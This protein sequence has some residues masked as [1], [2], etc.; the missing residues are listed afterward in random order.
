MYINY[1]D[2]PS[3]KSSFSSWLEKKI[4]L[5]SFILFIIMYTSQQETYMCMVKNYHKKRVICCKDSLEM[6]S[7]WQ[8][9]NM[10]FYFIKE[11]S[12]IGIAWKY[13]SKYIWVLRQLISS[14]N[15]IVASEDTEYLMIDSFFKLY[16]ISLGSHCDYTYHCCSIYMVLY[17]FAPWHIIEEM[18]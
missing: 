7:K 10:Y 4:V 11:H 18:K 1:D 9:Y 12:Y 5:L 16:S 3:V 15:S 8:L 6:R 17:Y 14:M 2:C 13:S